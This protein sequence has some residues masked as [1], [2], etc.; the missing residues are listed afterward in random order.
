ML[1][2][3]DS[4]RDLRCGKSGVRSGSIGV[5]SQGSN[6]GRWQP[7][8]WLVISGVRPGTFGV[9]SHLW[10]TL[11][12][13]HRP[14]L[15]RNAPRI[16]SLYFLK[17]IITILFGVSKHREFDPRGFSHQPWTMGEGGCCPQVAMPRALAADQAP[18]SPA[19]KRQ[20]KKN[21]E[22]V[23]M[24]SN[25]LVEHIVTK[26]ALARG[27]SRPL[28]AQGSDPDWLRPKQRR[29]FFY[30]CS[31]YQGYHH[32]SPPPPSLPGGLMAA[33]RAS[34]GWVRLPPPAHPR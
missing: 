18:T 14:G 1:K 28:G 5:K 11:A 31:N 19:S 27:D 29:L 12:L 21:P 30:G 24:R 23:A 13:A 15:V 9:G 32:P 34:P 2:T 7:R 4:I 25:L 6:Q 26:T 10:S 16:E 8:L 17:T 20:K 33:S 3:R 22:Q